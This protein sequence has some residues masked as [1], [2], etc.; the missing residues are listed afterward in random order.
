MFGF[1]KLTKS[2]PDAKETAK[3]VVL[4]YCQSWGQSAED[5]IKALNS[6]AKAAELDAEFIQNEDRTVYGWKGKDAEKAKAMRHEID[7][8]FP[9]GQ[10]ELEEEAIANI[11]IKYRQIK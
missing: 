5:K 2:L 3:H 4:Q 8:S 1:F 10:F 9:L 7:E 6:A 11:I